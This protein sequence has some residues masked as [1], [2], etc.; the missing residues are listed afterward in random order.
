MASYSGNVT[1]TYASLE[2]TDIE[3]IPVE[4]G[5]FPL[6]TL[7]LIT[8]GGSI[9]VVL[10]GIFVVRKKSKKKSSIA[11]EEVPVKPKSTEETKGKIIEPSKPESA[12]DTENVTTEPTTPTSMESTKE[13]ITE[14]SESTSKEDTKENANE[15][16]TSISPEKKKAKKAKKPKNKNI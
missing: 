2:I 15:T 1:Y 13:K 10:T 4:D 16:L 7:L 3:L 6:E 9:G 11:K 14:E 5:K 8:V 12:E